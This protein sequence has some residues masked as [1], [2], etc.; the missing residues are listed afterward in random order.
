M[1]MKLSIQRYRRWASADF[2]SSR[3]GLPINTAG[4]G[5]YKNA[6][7]GVVRMWMVHMKLL[8]EGGRNGRYHRAGRLRHQYQ[9]KSKRAIG[10]LT[11]SNYTL[12]Y[13]VTK[14]REGDKRYREEPRS[15]RSSIDN[16]GEGSSI[17]LEDQT[18]KMGPSIRRSGIAPDSPIAEDNIHDG[19][20]SGS[21]RIRDALM[22][23]DEKMRR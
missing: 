21:K 7:N 13:P 11:S 1:G 14:S 15:L 12:Q 8:V 17:D 4:V 23:D 19:N 9:R 3:M 5:G 20:H 6:S 10:E 16:S 18:R 2:P 22:A